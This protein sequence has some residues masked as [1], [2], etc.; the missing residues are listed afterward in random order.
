MNFHLTSRSFLVRVTGGGLVVNCSASR[1]LGWLREVCSDMASLLA[2][3][4][5]ARRKIKYCIGRHSYQ[6][7]MESFR[8]L[9]SSFQDFELV[10]GVN[11]VHS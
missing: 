6:N 1:I 9:P 2:V 5:Q 10:S 11:F 7:L 4:A 3:K 8:N